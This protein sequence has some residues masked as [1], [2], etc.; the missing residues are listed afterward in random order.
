MG[1]SALS[2][3]HPQVCNDGIDFS[4]TSCVADRH[5]GDEDA[6]PLRVTDINDQDIDHVPVDLGH[7][8]VVDVHLGTGVPGKFS[9]DGGLLVDQVNPVGEFLVV[10]GRRETLNRLSRGGLC[11]CETVLGV[12]LSHSDI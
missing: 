12:D 1:G 5:R 4:L 3:L 7:T 6:H 10:V 8:R 9:A 11:I 2:G